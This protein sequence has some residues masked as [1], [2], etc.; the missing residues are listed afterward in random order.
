LPFAESDSD[1]TEG[2]GPFGGFGDR[3]QGEG[4]GRSLDS[5]F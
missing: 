3:F 4:V 2:S 5:P 1:L